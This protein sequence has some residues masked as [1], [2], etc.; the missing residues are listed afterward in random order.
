MLMQ[1]FNI[2]AS[3][4]D[5]LEIPNLQI[6]FHGINKSGS[7]AMANV[8]RE[9]YSYAERSDEFISHYHE[10]NTTEKFIEK[11]NSFEYKK[12]S[13]V[14]GHYLYGAL[15]PAPTRLW[16]TQ[17]RHPLPRIVSCYQWLK[18]KYENN[19]FGSLFIDLKEFIIQSNRGVLNSQI[20]QLGAGYGQYK[21]SHL[22]RLSPRNLYE[23][24]I[25]NLESNVHTIGIA[26]FFE[27][28]IFSF[29]ILCGLKSV[30]PWTRDDRNKGRV[31]VSNLEGSLIELIQEFYEYDFLLYEYA[32]NRFSVQL[33]KL[34]IKSNDLTAYQDVCANQYKDRI[35]F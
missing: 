12:K 19:N 5:A 18:N 11:I 8:L 28:S 24:S 9:A 4:Y 31:L 34:K 14:V 22:K 3:G 15:K 33:K 20:I 7:L 27:E 16:V 1:R 13:F 6:V 29:A 35:L 26:E 21:K 32:L 25:D 23:I 30:L 10:G 2:S 17:F